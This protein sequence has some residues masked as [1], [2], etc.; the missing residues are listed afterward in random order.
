M[1]ELPDSIDSKYKFI[2]IAAQRC[3]MLQ[4]GAKAK[5]ETGNMRKLTSVAM[6]EVLQ[7]LIE[8]EMITSEDS[9]DK[10]SEDEKSK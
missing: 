10:A 3:D 6:E 2:S 5:I 7:D 8:F 1:R 4:K 9:E